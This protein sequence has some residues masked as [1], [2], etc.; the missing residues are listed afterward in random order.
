MSPEAAFREGFFNVIS[1][2]TTTGFANADYIKWSSPAIMII[3]LLLFTG[4][5]TGSTAGNIKIARHV[6]VFK[7]IKA[8]FI[9]LLH[10]NAIPNLR[11]NGKLIPEKASVSIMSFI[12]MYLFIFLTGTIIVVI[13]GPD[14]T[15]AS[16][17]VAA[18]LGN[19]GP[20]LGTVG[21]MSNYSHFPGITKLILSILMIIGRV[22][23]IAVL[24]LFTRSFWKF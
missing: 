1:I 23:I 6:I 5:C 12:I 13:T 8:A 21:P 2:I 18:S 11:F 7:A 9:K 19:I 24:S 4:A 20:G 10:P 3:F 22:E 16:S 14:V 17:S 15:S